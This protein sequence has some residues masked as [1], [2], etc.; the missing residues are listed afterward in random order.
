[1]NDSMQKGTLDQLKAV[2][3]PAGFRETANDLEPYLTEWRG[4]FRGHT[5]LMLLPT[6]TAQVSEILRICN[7]A[8]TGVVPQGGN[9]G[10]AGGAIPGLAGEGPQILL[11]AGRLNRVR[12]PQ[13]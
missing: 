1:M 6:T 10:L 11:G 2:V 4:L 8:G 13:W 3:G 5:P 9:T 7:A 12:W